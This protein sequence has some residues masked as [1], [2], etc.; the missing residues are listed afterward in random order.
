LMEYLTLTDI[1]FFTS[2]DPYQAVSGT[3][4]YAMSAGCPVISNSFVLAKEMLDE[5]TGII[6]ETA[7]ETELAEKAIMLLQNDDLRKK[8]SNSALL[9]MR[10]TN[11][12]KVGRKHADL[13]YEIFGKPVASNKLSNQVAG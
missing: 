6:L 9:K 4:L 11:W 1:Y 5:E 3:F 7:G 10:D 8:M 12:K 2:K 13:F